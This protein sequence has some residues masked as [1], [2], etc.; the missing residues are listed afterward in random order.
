MPVPVGMPP[1][2]TTLTL[3]A[4]V[5]RLA[6][7]LTAARTT[8]D[9]VGHL[10]LRGAVWV[11]GC[12]LGPPHGPSLIVDKGPGG[13]RHVGTPSKPCKRVA[14]T[15]PLLLRTGTEG[16][17]EFLEDV[18]RV[19]VAKHVFED[20]LRLLFAHLLPV[21]PTPAA[22]RVSATRAAESAAAAAK[23]IAA[24]AKGIAATA[25]A[26]AA[27]FKWVA[28]LTAKGGTWGPV[29]LLEEPF[30]PDSKKA[31]VTVTNRAGDNT[32]VVK[33]FTVGG[34][35][36]KTSQLFTAPALSNPKGPRPTTVPSSR[37]A[38][39]KAVRPMDAITDSMQH[40][41]GGKSVS[42]SAVLV[43]NGGDGPMA[44]SA[45]VLEKKKGAR[46]ANTDD[47]TKKFGLCIDTTSTGTFNLA[48]MR[49]AD[50][51]DNALTNELKKTVA[52]LQALMGC[53]NVDSTA[54]TVAKVVEE[55]GKPFAKE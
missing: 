44:N 34:N 9:F 33:V 19:S 23:G 29:G 47:T 4:S 8:K 20:L 10:P 45:L 48:M 41:D 38:L 6:L 7:R 46:S 36:G 3:A 37:E 14:P 35:S 1:K 32:P 27:V 53:S 39:T 25:A 55:A 40:E 26:A 21:K 43:L 50:E 42:V 22:K 5:E 51:R 12:G 31:P 52:I 16:L 18:L 24:A 15:P 13:L 54:E 30:S 11:R 17:V 2:R 28:A 49:T